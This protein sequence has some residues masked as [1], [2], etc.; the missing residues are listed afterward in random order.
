MGQQRRFDLGPI[1]ATPGALEALGRNG[2]NGLELLAR[3]AR[4][5]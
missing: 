4:G 3:H 2:M 5:D 1:V